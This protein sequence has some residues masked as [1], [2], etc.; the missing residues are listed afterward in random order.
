MRFLP[1]V[2][3]SLLRRKIRTTFTLLSILVA[4]VLFGY[5]SAIRVAFG[6]GIDLLGN[7]RLL[8][9]HRVSIIQPLPESYQPRIEAIRGVAETAHASWFGG[10]YQDPR[11]FFTQLAVQPERFLQLYP[12]FR[13]PAD[14]KAVWLGDRTGAIAGRTLAERFGWE[15]GDR[16]P[17]QGTIWRRKNGDTWEFTLDGIY[18]GAEQG[19]DTTQ[20][21]FHYDYF[22]EAREFGQGVVGWYVVRIDDP[23]RAVDI[24]EQID[25]T[26]ANSP[27]ETKTSTEKA[28]VQAFAN[29]IGSIGT[30]L[31]AVLGAVFFTILLVTG[32]T[33]AQSV[34]ERTREL[35]VLK[36][37]G[38]SNGQVLVLVLLES[39]ALALTGG[40]VGLAIAW[41]L[42]QRGDP[43]GAFLPAFY[44]P[45]E[46]VMYGVLC[47]IGLGLVSGLLPALQA[48]RLRIADALRRT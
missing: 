5:L 37:V 17:I 39:C 22:D 43:T 35:A 12:E 41:A 26:F 28:F 16:I 7:D 23:A 15:V 8:T 27:A 40:G 42:I 1:L 21:L 20:F 44:L 33:M 47:I 46:D 34:R 48:R 10:V 3:R 45:A 9:I 24:A 29:Q 30:I 14:Q 25:A 2:W 32:N 13:L 11:N 4:F 19:T 38:F 18:D 36:T 31:M 6:L